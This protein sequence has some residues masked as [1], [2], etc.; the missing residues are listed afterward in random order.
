MIR[1]FTVD[2]F[3]SLKNSDY[4]ILEFDAR[5]DKKSAFIASPVIGFAGANASGKSNIL[6]ALTFVFWFMQSSFFEIEE[7]KRIPYEAFLTQN[8]QPTYFHLIFAKKINFEGE[9]KLVDFEY[10]LDIFNQEVLVEKLN[11][12]PKKRQRKVF[13]RQGNEI[14]F[15]SKVN[16]LG[17]ENIANLR[18]NCSFVSFAAQFASQ[19]VIRECKNYQFDSNLDSRSV[20]LQ[21]YVFSPTIMK[22][23][24]EDNHKKERL[25][26]LLYI[27]DLG[28]SDFKYESIIQGNELEK[29]GDNSNSLFHKIENDK[30]LNNDQKRRLVSITNTLLILTKN[31]INSEG[32]EKITF[33]HQLDNE[34]ASLPHTFES[35]GTLKF[36]AIAAK[37]LEALEKGSLL[38]I[39][40]IETRLHQNLIA[41]LIVL[42]QNKYE[43]P[44]GAQLIFSFHNSSLM[45][46]LTPEQLWFTEKNDRGA[47]EIFCTAD[48]KDIK[49]LYKQNLEEL[50]RLGKFGAK[51]RGI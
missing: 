27:A 33:Q 6:Q 20:S 51:P 29:N 24:Q 37:V 13:S 22:H 3:R 31:K 32:I 34:I 23:F 41:Y 2:N 10:R 16:R 14:T 40:E 36:I 11:Y 17:Q 43:N 38:I 39:D 8:E 25:K 30:S 42:F 4:N 48:F 19:E 35:S 15:G 1:Y 9:E 7:G 49:Q 5:L 50:Y 44:H 21:D 18:S 12:Y 47:T 26:Q 46:N 45:K 28:I